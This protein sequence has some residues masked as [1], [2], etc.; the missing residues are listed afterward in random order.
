MNLIVTIYSSSC[1]LFRLPCVV[2]L[3]GTQSQKLTTVPIFPWFHIPLLSQ[4][5]TI[6][7]KKMCLN[8]TQQYHEDPYLDGMWLGLDLRIN[9]KKTRVNKEWT[10]CSNATHCRLKS[11]HG[12][13]NMYDHL[14]C[15]RIFTL[16]MDDLFIWAPN[17]TRQTDMDTVQ[18]PRRFLS[19]VGQ[20]PSVPK[21]D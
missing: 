8:Q 1:H 13:G 20:N 7:K 5:K 17:N 19:I 10:T 2:F 3:I 12:Q 14:T 21:S 16:I 15:T 9:T 18:C 11:Q 6:V 4:N